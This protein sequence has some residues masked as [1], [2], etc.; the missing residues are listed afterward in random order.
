[1]LMRARLALVPGLSFEVARISTPQEQTLASVQGQEPELARL[2][3]IFA[4]M[5]APIFACAGRHRIVIWHSH[6]RRLRRK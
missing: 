4:A 2:E 1:M 5:R 3:R 6:C